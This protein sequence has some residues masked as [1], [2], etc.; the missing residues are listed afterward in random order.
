RHPPLT[1]VVRS[2]IF[3]RLTRADAEFP[4]KEP[5][6]IPS[7]ELSRLL[8]VQRIGRHRLR[9]RDEAARDQATAPF[10]D[11]QHGERVAVEAGDHGTDILLACQLVY[12]PSACL[13]RQIVPFSVISSA[14]AR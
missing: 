4:V 9:V 10:M 8:A 12:A 3:Q 1:A 14:P 7:G 13:H 5:R 2:L 6:I 11:A